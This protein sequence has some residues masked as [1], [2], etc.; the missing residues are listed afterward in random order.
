MLKNYDPNFRYGVHTIEV[1][2]QQWDYK[3]TV[4]VKIAGQRK[5]DLDRRE[6]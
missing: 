6:G 5:C 1:T 3:G 4:R 2:L